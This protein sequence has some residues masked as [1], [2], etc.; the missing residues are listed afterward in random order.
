MNW[1]S[2][3]LKKPEAPP[4]APPMQPIAKTSGEDIGALRAALAHAE[5]AERAPLAARLG[6]ALACNSRSPQAD[7]PPE[8]WVAAICQADKVHAL[9]WI[10]G[11]GDDARLAEVA[12]QAHSAEVRYAAAQ[13][14]EASTLLEQVAQASRD[15][16]KRVYRHCADQLRQRREAEANLRHAQQFADGLRGLLTTA[17]Q[18][19]TRLLELKKELAGLAGGGPLREEC[20][21]LMEQAFAQLRREAQER[22]ALQTHLDQAAT[23]AS[24]CAHAAWPW[25]TQLAGWRERRADLGR[26]PLPEWLAEQ[27]AAAAL[28]TALFE[29][30][31]LLG[32]LD[33]DLER[34]EACERFL[35]TLALDSPLD[36]EQ[37]AAWDALP[38]P[39]HPEA[40]AP[41]LARWQAASDQ[42]PAVVAIAVEVPEEAVAAPPPSAPPRQ[43]KIDQAALRAG[44]EQLEQAVEQGHL[45][46]ADAAAKRIKNLL[47]GETLHGALEA[48]LHGLQ[49]RHEEMRGWARWGTVQVREQLVASARALLEGEHDVDE[50]AHVIPKLRE[51]WKRLNS[52]GPVAKG[53]WESFDA[54][55]EQAYRPVAA[56][57][58]EQAAAQAAALAVR[59]AQCAG[60]EAEVAA[61]VWEYADFKVVEARR[62]QLIQQW[63]EAPA[64]GFRAEQPLRKRFD[65]MIADIDRHLGAARASELQR[66]EQIVAA[67]T[68]LKDQ[69]DLRQA[70]AEAKALQERWNQPNVPVRLKRGDEQRLWQQF[71]AACDAVFARQ[72]AL[73][74]EQTA[75]RQERS[76][77]RQ[78]LLDEFAATLATGDG[79]ELKQAL[80]RFRGDWENSAPR[81]AR[82]PDSLNRGSR[83]SQ[84]RSSERAPAREPGDGLDARAEALQKQARQRLD[85]QRRSQYRAH[86]DVMARKSA[87]AE[88]VEAAALAAGPLE[89]VVAAAQEEWNALP[90]VTGKH[91]KPLVRRF[92]AAVQ[93]TRPDLEAGHGER[94]SLLLDLEIALGL[95]SPERYAAI[96]NDR[97]LE[98]LQSRFGA[99]PAHDS[100]PEEML[101]RWFATPALPDPAFALRIAAV[102]NHMAEQAIQPQ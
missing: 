78:Q 16:D 7:D 53:Q 59:E 14:I 33:L 81:S 102:V 25:A 84:G 43:S 88:R 86:L 94:E 100:A 31:T 79:S 45:A 30:D 83:P 9:A 66:R 70:M 1:L 38:K 46:D 101:A 26:A 3:F 65:A 55:L 60:W 74:A 80:A 29:I 40:F 69:P 77:A 27:S 50:L 10:G 28:N 44:M 17:P 24:D 95:P 37:R 22:R 39:D 34:S 68:A 99:T 71:R 62:A 92:A 13:R 18:Q 20:D 49:A 87:L 52:H 72:A 56:L 75:Q 35:D 15:K 73:R 85:E 41:L 54:A 21:A 93:A 48:R 11:L 36:A 8:T 89:A 58:A 23:L 47:A 2:R 51:E 67:A 6:R 96:R 42:A 82:I 19:Q 4:T 5:T 90:A 64:A 32:A 98:R 63:R 97:Q 61:M 91:E 76:Q 12:K 57:R